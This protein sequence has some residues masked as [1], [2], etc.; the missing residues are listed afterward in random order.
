MYRI[1][2]G[3]VFTVPVMKTNA[4]FH[5]QSCHSFNWVEYQSFGRKEVYWRGWQGPQSGESF[6]LCEGNAI[7]DEHLH[8]HPCD[9]LLKISITNRDRNDMAFLKRLPLLPCR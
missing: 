2:E 3:Y 4:V 7:H 6:H 1:L 9:L 5:R 8:W